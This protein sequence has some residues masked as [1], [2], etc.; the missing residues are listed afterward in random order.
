MKNK[1]NNLSLDEVKKV[2]TLAKLSLTSQELNKFQQ[3]LSQVVEYVGKL[4]EVDTTSVEPTNQVTGLE[5][6]FREDEVK[7]SL[8]QKE[9]LANAPKK[10]RN[11][12]KVE[13]I[14]NQ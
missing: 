12:F 7:P 8:T 6:I 1:T 5:N 9:V 3:Q 4:S 11:Y 14:F 10:S 13:T 2:A